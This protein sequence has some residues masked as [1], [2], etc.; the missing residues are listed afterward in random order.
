MT[1]RK[2]NMIILVSVKAMP[3]NVTEKS[4]NPSGLTQYKLISHSHNSSTWEFH[5]GRAPWRDTPVTQ[6]LPS[7][8][9]GPTVPPGGWLHLAS[10]KVGSFSGPGPELG[11]P[12][13]ITST[14]KPQLHNLPELQRSTRKWSSAL[15]PGSGG[16]GLVICVT[17]SFNL[18]ECL[19]N[20]LFKLSVI[21]KEMMFTAYDWQP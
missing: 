21:W 18:K 6:T 2:I 19:L 13:L 16:N 10:W 17:I 9:C 1:I 8:T 7:S 20:I 12:P 11:L 5:L 14:A 3:T 15:R 4:P